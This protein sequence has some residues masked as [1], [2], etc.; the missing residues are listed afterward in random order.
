MVHWSDMLAVRPEARNLG[1]GRRLKEFQRHE[2]APPW[3][4]RHLLDVRSSR[5]PQ[6]APQLQRLRRADPRVRGGHVR[7]D[8]RVRSTAASAP[9]VS[10]SP[11]PSPTRRCVNASTRR[12]PRG[13]SRPHASADTE[14]GQ[15]HALENRGLAQC[16]SRCRRTSTA[17]SRL[18]ATRRF[19]WR[20]STRA[21]FRRAL[22]AGLTVQGFVIDDCA[23]RGYYLLARGAVL[24]RSRVPRFR[25]EQVDLESRRCARASYS[26]RR[27][28]M[29]RRGHTLPSALS[30]PV[31][32]GRHPMLRLDR[33]VL[34][35]IRLALEGALSHLLRHRHRAP[36][37]PARAARRR[38]RGDLGG[39]R[40]RRAA[41]LQ[42]GDDRHGWFAIRE[43]L[44]PRLLGRS[45]D[46]PEVIHGVLDQNVRG[47]NM[48]KAALEMG[49]WA[50]AA[51][52]RRRVALATARRHARTHPDRH[53]ARH[54]ERRP[55]RSCSAPARRSRRAIARSS[56][57][58]SR[59][60]DVEYVRAV[61][62]RSG[63]RGASHGRRQLGVHVSPMPI[64]S[65][66]STR[67][68]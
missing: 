6:R 17:C 47:H 19:V 2:R 25:S 59:E 46:G 54:P 3:R 32:A 66:S 40:R 61:R 38:R 14:R 20:H 44:A 26:A 37:L 55:T 34:R 64:T 10:S 27:F 53:L 43:W 39:V 63:R 48:A 16:V 42:P 30:P 21:A 36:H 22:D 7:R 57:R 52:K 31:P 49:M 13:G 23:N 45:F 4:R 50:L 56:S 58:S 1:L 11:G 5:G 18:I 33:L 28:H 9:T 60:Q 62:T 8:A 12:M 65:R 15:R 41:E 24:A 68:T 51:T 67:S 29:S 35:E